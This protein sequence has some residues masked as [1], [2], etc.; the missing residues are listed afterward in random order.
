MDNTWT[1]MEEALVFYL[2]MSMLMKMKMCA[3]LAFATTLPLYLAVCFEIVDERFLPSNVLG[4]SERHA[5]FS[6]TK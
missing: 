1:A 3:L 2:S 6:G 5:Y 4:I